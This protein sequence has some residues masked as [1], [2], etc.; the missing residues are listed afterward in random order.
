MVSPRI[1]ARVQAKVRALDSKVP[2]EDR[3]LQIVETFE[4]YSK[5]RARKTTFLVAGTGEAIVPIPD[6]IRRYIRLKGRAS[7]TIDL[8]EYPITTGT[9]DQFHHDDEWHFYPRGASKPHSLKFRRIPALG[10][11]FRIHAAVMHDAQI[12]APR[13]GAGTA[14]GTPGSTEHRYVLTSLDDFGETTPTV[15]IVIADG[16]ATLSPTDFIRLTW[17]ADEDAH[18]GGYK[19][20]R[21]TPSPGLVGEVVDGTATFD[22]VAPVAASPGEAAPIENTAEHTAIGDDEPGIVAGAAYRV[23]LLDAAAHVNVVEKGHRVGVNRGT[24]TASR[25]RLAETYLAEWKRLIGEV[26]RPFIRVKNRRRDT[27]YGPPIFRVNERPRRE[28]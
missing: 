24:V 26:P 14:Q 16:P 8:I 23:H 22:D 6:P 10:E 1:D 9:A 11:F 18:V 7:T 3:H 25:I 5:F 27:A 15:E 13:D 21:T 2:T 12:E 20:Y 28:R 17:T 4:E 19:V